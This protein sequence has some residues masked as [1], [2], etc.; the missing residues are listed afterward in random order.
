[1]EQITSTVGPSNISSSPGNPSPGSWDSSGLAPA[2][3]LSFCFLLGL[4]GNISVILLKS[5][6]QHMSS[7]S[8]T[9]ML[10]LAM[11][12]ILCLLTLPLWI[13]ALL[14]GWTFSLAACKTLS[15]LVYC[16]IYSSLLTVTT[17]SVQR[18]LQVVYL[19]RSLNLTGQRWQLVL[20]LAALILASPA[21]VVDELITDQQ[22]PRC[23]PP[24]SEA[25]MLPLLLTETCIGS[26]SLFI[27]VFSY[28]CIQRKV[29]QGALFNRPQTSRL[30]SSIIV[31]FVV[32]WMPYLMVNVLGVLGFTLSN[33]NLLTFWM[34]SSDVFGA[35]IFLNTCVN[36]LLYAFASCTMCQ[37]NVQE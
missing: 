28:I 6:W 25:Q 21:L 29:S 2:V 12:D 16:S 9:L 20:W 10:N 7:L 3:L 36:P 24:S 34:K 1:M 18:Y 27:V 22:W 4:P 15:Y 31:T 32:L 26:V 33:S 13:Y 5:K 17:L 19:Q 23:R 14:F 37:K 30:I 11:A 8:Q 35:L